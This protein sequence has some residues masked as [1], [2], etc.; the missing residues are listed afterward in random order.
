MPERELINGRY[1]LISVIGQGA[2]GTV[3]RGRDEMLGRD[4]AIKKII[5]SVDLD[6]REHAELKALA[7][8]EARATAVLNHP[9]VITVFDVIEHDQAPVI[10]MELIE[11]ESLAEI[12]RTRVLLPWRRVAEIGVAMA[13]ALAVAHEAGIVHRDLKPANVLVAGRRVVITDF[14]I[15]RRSGERTAGRPGEASGTPAFMAPE[16]AENAA[17][18]PAADLWSLGATL[19]NAVEGKPPFEGP[20]YAS[21]LLLLLTQEPPV[22]QR[23]GPLTPLITSLLGKNPER[24][25]SIDQVTEDLATALRAEATPAPAVR[26]PQ[27]PAPAPAGNAAPATTTGTQ[28]PSPA[29]PPLL[30]LKRPP[31]SAGRNGILAA[32]GVVALIGLLVFLSPA[33]ARFGA[34]QPSRSL[35][36]DGVGVRKNAATLTGPLAFSPKGDLLAAGETL[37]V[38]SGTAVELFDAPN[39]ARQGTFPVGGHGLAAL[40]FS[41]DGS[42]LAIADD[43]G[44]V[45]VWD[46][47]TRKRIA[48]T[49]VNPSGGTTTDDLNTLE[50]SRDGKSLLTCDGNGRY[51]KWTI[52]DDKPTLKTIPG[53]GVQCRALSPD[54]TTYTAYTESSG[55]LTLWKETDGHLKPTVLPAPWPST[56]ATV[57]S[58]VFSPDGRTLAV[59]RYDPAG[60]Q[61]KESGP[62]V[63]EL[64]DVSSHTRLATHDLTLYK[65]AGL[66]FTPDGKT[67]AATAAD[68]DITL[69]KLGVYQASDTIESQFEG[70]PDTL[71]FSHQ[72]LAAAGNDNTIRLWDLKTTHLVTTWP[73]GTSY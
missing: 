67:L 55:E 68:G 22:P 71:A 3:W 12:L 19:F 54:G 62:G 34:H 30:P 57:S 26:A 10:V 42:R 11:G 9:G 35:P 8:E 49:T 39:H 1:R 17:A 25:P 7:M 73:A 38:L 64:W 23:A 14:G 40:T 18:S 4:V 32:L 21:V 59:T 50:F 52:A 36:A 31:R 2:M 37:P 45:G 24:R 13:D 6:E 44:G 48:A 20:N 16:Q 46:I 53:I 70:G 66:A 61:T 65:G 60:S 29:P 15:A 63:V 72:F 27:P 33:H 51:G 58:T 69:W 5:L 56:T 43:S 47:A 28:A 41:P